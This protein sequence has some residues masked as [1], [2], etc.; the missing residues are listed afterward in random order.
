MGVDGSGWEWVRA[1]FSINFFIIV[2]FYY[3]TYT[4]SKNLHSVIA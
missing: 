1:Q 4:I 2:C 3:V